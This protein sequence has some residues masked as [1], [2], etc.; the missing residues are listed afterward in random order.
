MILLL[1]IQ[2]IRLEV[3]KFPKIELLESFLWSIVLT[4]LVLSLQKLISMLPYYVSNTLSLWIARRIVSWIHYKLASCS[5]SFLFCSG[6][7]QS[8]PNT[9][10]PND[11]IHFVW[12][13]VFILAL[14]LFYRNIFWIFLSFIISVFII[15]N[16]QLAF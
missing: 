16:P 5:L 12:A 15:L 14:I 3:C 2:P 11:F 9:S 10:F 8:N 6:I 7:P 1:D 13:I 4:I